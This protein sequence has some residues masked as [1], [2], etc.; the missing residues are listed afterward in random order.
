[1]AM[2]S[3]EI[4]LPQRPFHL[5][6]SAPIEASVLTASATGITVPRSAL[7]PAGKVAGRTLFKVN[8]QA[9]AHLQQVSVHV[10]LCGKERCVVTGT[11]QAGDRIVTAHGSVLLQLHDGDP[12]SVSQPVAAVQP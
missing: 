6:D 4:D 11:L 8:G 5:P 7:R 1:L 2:G 10:L 9:K 3:L 12:V